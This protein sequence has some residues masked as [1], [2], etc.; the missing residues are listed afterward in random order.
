MRTVARLQTKGLCTT[1]SVAYTHAATARMQARS[2]IT[3][4]DCYCTLAV[5]PLRHNP[6]LVCVATSSLG[7]MHP[8]AE[9]HG[10]GNGEL[11]RGITPSSLSFSKPKEGAQPSSSGR[12]LNDSH[13][14]G[15]PA[16]GGANGV[17]FLMPHACIPRVQ[18]LGLTLTQTAGHVHVGRVQACLPCAARTIC[19]H[20]MPK[21]CHR[22][23]PDIHMR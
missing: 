4:S 15:G 11:Q 21:S 16:A 13:M 9:L 7:C 8:C 6:P 10:P 5:L 17:C 1:C 2:S 14:N 23:H 22:N 19:K 12:L 3:P 18:S 20:A